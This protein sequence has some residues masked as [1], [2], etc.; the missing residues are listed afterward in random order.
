M[1]CPENRFVVATAFRRFRPR[2][3]WSPPAGRRRLAG[4]PPGAPAGRGGA[5]LLALTKWDE[6]FEDTPPYRIPHW[7]TLPFPSTPRC[8]TGTAPSLV[9]ISDTFDQKMRAIQCYGRS[10]TPSASS[11]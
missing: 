5:L 3:A 1:D 6:R 9:N 11:A 10:S 7:S 4:P 2:V 8:G